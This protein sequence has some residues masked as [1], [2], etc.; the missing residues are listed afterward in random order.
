MPVRVTIT[1]PDDWHHHFRD[2]DRME[3]VTPLVAR[4]FQR[5]IAMPN[6]VPPVSTTERG[7][8]RKEPPWLPRE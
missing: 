5:A 7:L 1:S 8:Q 2:G 4:Q 3:A 6:L